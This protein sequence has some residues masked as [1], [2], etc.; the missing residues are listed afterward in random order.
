[1]KSWVL[2]PRR[3]GVYMLRDVDATVGREHLLDV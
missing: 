1:M 3:L 2:S